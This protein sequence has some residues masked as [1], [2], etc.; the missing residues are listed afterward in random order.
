[1]QLKTNLKAQSDVNR[2]LNEKQLKSLASGKK[3]SWGSKGPVPSSA[4]TEI[5]GRRLHSSSKG[6]NRSTEHLLEIIDHYKEK[7][8]VSDEEIRNLQRQRHLLEQD[9]KLKEK[10]SR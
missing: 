8:L 9:V 4:Q 6:G 5:G 2:T 7:M 3:V 10:K 1:M